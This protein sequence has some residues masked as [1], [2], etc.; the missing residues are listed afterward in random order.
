MAKM[1]SRVAR[2]RRHLNYKNI[3][4]LAALSSLVCLTVAPQAGARSVRQDL[5]CPYGSGGDPWTATG[6]AAG[7]PFN[8]GVSTPFSAT[9]SGPIRFDDIGLTTTSAT[10]YAYYAAAIPPASSCTS[11]PNAPAPIAQVIDFKLAASQSLESTSGLVTLP[12]GASEIEFNYAPGTTGGNASFTM[13][14][15]TF[16]STGLPLA[17]A[18]DFIFNTNGT[19]FGAVSEDGTS[20]TLNAVPLGWKESSGV[21]SAPEMDPAFA[22]AGLALLLGAL[23]VVRGNRRPLAASS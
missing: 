15:V 19:L 9:L 16:T 4:A 13:G 10:Q 20:I 14:G 8:S 7:S 1:S 23:A 21:A 3:A 12:T 17:T 11:T 22:M 2:G 6:T 18:N 5:P